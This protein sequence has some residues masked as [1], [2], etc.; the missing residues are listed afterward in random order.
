MFYW[1]EKMFVEERKEQI[2]EMVRKFG[3]VKVKELSERFDVTEDCIRKDLASLEK[4]NL[5]K[6]AYGG[7]VSI[8]SNPHA[9]EVS[10]RK[11]QNLEGKKIIASKAVELIQEGDVVFLDLSTTNIEVAKLIAVSNK[12]ITVITNML[13]VLLVLKEATQRVI[14]VGGELNDER[15]G[16]FGAMTIQILLQFK[17]DIAFLGAAGINVYDNEVTTYGVDDGLTKDAALKTSRRT[18]LLAEVNKFSHDGNY[19][20]A[21]IT[22]FDGMI[23]DM[24]LSDVVKNK[25]TQYSIELI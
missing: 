25:V 10:A 2:L 8:R 1:S 22:D 14:F 5:L 4:R 18:Y 12:K 15:D 23:T 19:K 17:F 13:E 11:C 7:A 3:K 21:A 9:I 24:G 16:F 20:Y 6:R